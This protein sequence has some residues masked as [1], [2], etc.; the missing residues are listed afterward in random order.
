M[1]KKIEKLSIKQNYE[2]LEKISEGNFGTVF[3][4]VHKKTGLKSPTQKKSSNS[5]LKK[6]R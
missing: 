6:N 2:I 1:Q 3:K 4:A 5:C